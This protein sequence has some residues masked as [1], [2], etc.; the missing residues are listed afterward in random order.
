MTEKVKLARYR[1]TSYFVGY[2]GDGA[3]KQYTWTGSKNGK[4][5]VKEV[6]RELV[7]WLTMSSVCFDKGELVL[8]EENEESKEITDSINDVETYVNNTHTKEEIEAMIK[9]STAAQLKK[10][11][12]E[13]TVEAEKQFVI[14]VASEF[15]DDIAKGKLTVLADWMGVEDSSILFD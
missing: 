9:S 13:I 15:S 7:D 10:Q 3:N 4:V 8:I 14:D 12:T 11:L 1:N 5:D 2:T 6:P